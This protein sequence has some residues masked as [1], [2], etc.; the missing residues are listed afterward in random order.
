MDQFGNQK[1][2]INH[3]FKYFFDLNKK[4]LWASFQ[5]LKD[6]FTQVDRVINEIV[7]NKMF[8]VTN[9]KRFLNESKSLAED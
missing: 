1:F 8:F 7:T 5:T 6:Q 3:L 2:K 9:L 4:R